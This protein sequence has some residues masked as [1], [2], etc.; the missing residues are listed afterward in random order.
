MLTVTLVLFCTYTHASI[1]SYDK[2]YSKEEQVGG[3]CY[4]LITTC[5]KKMVRR[6]KKDSCGGGGGG[7]CRV[8]SVSTHV[9]T[10]T[11]WMDASEHW[12]MNG[13]LSVVDGQACTT[14]KEL[15]L[16]E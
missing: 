15:C 16:D 1:H 10:H 13:F 12:Q 11:H 14:L 6:A 7:G 5:R 8:A 3:N 4:L 2:L 9:C